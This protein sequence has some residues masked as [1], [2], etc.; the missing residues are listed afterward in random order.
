MKEDRNYGIDLL[1]IIAMLYVVIGHSLGKGGLLYACDSHSL[2]GVMCW[3]LY[4]LSDSCINIFALV[5]G[6]VCYKDG[7]TALHIGRT[8][9]IYLQTV[10]YGVLSTV[11]C[12]MLIDSYSATISDYYHVLFPVSHNAYWYTTAYVGIF[13]LC[14]I[15]NSGIKHINDRVLKL[16]LPLFIVLYCVLAMIT[17]DIFYQH[18][19]YTAFW[20]LILYTIG[21]ILKK[22]GILDELKP[23]TV[24]LISMVCIMAPML[25]AY[26]G[27]SITAIGGNLDL[28]WDF[29]YDY[30]SPF[31]VILA[32]M[33]IALF[34]RLKMPK[35]IKQGISFITPSVYAVYLINASPQFYDNV[36]DGS[37]V[38]LG[39]KAT[40]IMLMEF[41]LINVIFLVMAVLADK[42][43]IL[44]F[45][46]IG[47]S[48]LCRVIDKKAK[49]LAIS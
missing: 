40:I 46:A 22:T 25:W 47:I 10:F 38:F 6:Y 42:I 39:D 26:R 8:I 28:N 17:E 48:R 19:G 49:A 4:T 11:A 41:F 24:L 29:L 34:T 9:D 15:V 43:R 14:P 1:R 45:N 36:L 2:A 5:S 30:I 35:V 16:M 37:T 7:S 3:F 20:L 13:M 27:I 23:W 18:K 31:L 44:L 12:S 21:G 33:H 32:A